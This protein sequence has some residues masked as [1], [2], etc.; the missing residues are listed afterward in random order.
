MR[1]W[2]HKLDKSVSEKIALLSKVESRMNQEKWEG[3]RAKGKRRYVLINGLKAALICCTLVG[4]IMVIRPAPSLFRDVRFA[5]GFVLVTFLN[6]WVIGNSLR[7]DYEK[8]Y[9]TKG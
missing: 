2:S 6:G 4:L 5:V 9:Q 1:K 7:N 8:K 3:I